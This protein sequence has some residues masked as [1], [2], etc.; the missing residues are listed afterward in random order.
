[1]S[2]EQVSQ[3]AHSYNPYI[4]K[5]ESELP[6]VGGMPGLPSE[7]KAHLDEYLSQK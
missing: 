2:L 5:G 6:W 4:W 7:F 3:L 1:M